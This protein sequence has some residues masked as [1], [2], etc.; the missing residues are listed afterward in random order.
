MEAFEEGDGKNEI[1][2]S[3]K[4]DISPAIIGQGRGSV[5]SIA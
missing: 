1:M 4:L 3:E 2:G 5:F